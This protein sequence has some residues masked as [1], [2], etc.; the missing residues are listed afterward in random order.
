MWYCCRALRLITL[1]GAVSSLI[2]G[3]ALLLP[4]DLCIDILCLKINA[5]IAFVFLFFLTVANFIPQNKTPKYRS[6]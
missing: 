1:P 4:I 5:L 3:L 2:Y 6:S